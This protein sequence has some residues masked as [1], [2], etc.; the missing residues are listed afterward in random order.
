[1]TYRE[2][3]LVVGALSAFLVTPLL[4]AVMGPIG[5]LCNVLVTTHIFMKYWNADNA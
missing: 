3:T 5:V 2:Q 1:M 4:W